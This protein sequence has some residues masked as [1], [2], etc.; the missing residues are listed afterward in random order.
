M[1][2]ILIPSSQFKLQPFITYIRSEQNYTQMNFASFPEITSERLLLRKMEVFDAAVI[3][4]LRS[5]KTVNEFIERSE[6]RRTK[7]MAQAI[8]FITEVNDDFENN[9]SVSWGITFKQEA[10]IIGTICLW[11]FSENN[12]VAEVGY[13]LSPK[14][15]NKGIMSEA[16]KCVIDFGFDKLKLDKIEAFTH[17][18][19]ENSKKLLEKTGFHFM[20]HRK[21]PAN[22]S[23]TRYELQNGYS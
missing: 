15:Q 18:K 17:N 4:Y 22:V 14:F 11:N 20:E 16:L 23:N 10:E 12:T 13:N 8:E 21:D 2:K 6:N 7:T 5:D 1:E 3:L 9:K 19:N